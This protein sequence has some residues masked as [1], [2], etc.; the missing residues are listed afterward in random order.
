M[1]FIGT[2]DTMNIIQAAT[3]LLEKKTF[4]RSVSRESAE[5]SINLATRRM[6]T[7]GNETI[8]KLQREMQELQ[9]KTAKEIADITSQ[10]DAVIL[11]TKKEAQAEITKAKEEANSTVQAVKNALAK[12][13]ASKVIEKILPNGNKL[14]RKANKNGAVMEKE[15][16]LL[17]NKDGEIS[18]HILNAKVTDLTG[19][20]RKTKYNP[21]T[22]KPVNTYTDTVKPRLYEYNSKGENTAVKDVNVK[23]LK[24]EKPTLVTQTAPHEVNAGFSGERAIGVD[25]IFSD[26][27]S[28]TIAKISSNNNP[29]TIVTKKDPNGQV[30]ERTTTWTENKTQRIERFEKDGSYSETEKFLDNNNKLITLTYYSALDPM[31]TGQRRINVGEKVINSIGKKDIKRQKDEFGFYTDTSK[32]KYTFPKGSGKKSIKLEGSRESINKFVNE[33]EKNAQA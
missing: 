4:G 1:T 8:S 14:I 20:V 3:Q 6:A 33:L 12:A 21:L 17:K 18:E 26:G 28:E 24:S 32:G 13:K 9:G 5:A 25:R 23:K 11:Q 30:Y 29:R 10:K 22:G 7:L 16:V 15:V 19:N 2:N 27:S 31:A